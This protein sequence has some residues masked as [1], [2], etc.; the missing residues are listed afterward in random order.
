MEEER[1]FKRENKEGSRLKRKHVAKAGDFI[2]V[3]NSVDGL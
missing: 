2:E 1:R 3:T